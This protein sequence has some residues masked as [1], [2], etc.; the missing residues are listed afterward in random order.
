MRAL[1]IRTLLILLVLALASCASSSPDVAGDGGNDD[2]PVTQD[3]P[4][5]DA[6]PEENVPTAPTTDAARDV[7][8]TID[9]GGADSPDAGLI[10]E[11]DAGA[12][13]CG[14]TF[15]FPG[16]MFGFQP[17]PADGSFHAVVS[18]VAADHLV[19]QPDVGNS[20]TFAWRGPSLVTEFSV[21]QDVSCQQAARWSIVRSTVRTAE[22]NSTFSNTGIAQ[23]GTIPGGATYSI[24]PQCANVLF[25]PCNG[26]TT[27]TVIHTYYR[28]VVTLAGESADIPMETTVQL[29]GW[30]ITN[31]FHDQGSV[32]STTP[33]CAIDFVNLELTSALGPP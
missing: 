22:I 7:G 31:V 26:T 10:P 24:V 20:V 21:G 8:P 19:L 18:E 3:A 14:Q 5:T 28:I 6:A 33:N 15:T 30:R 16:S 12:P 32:R 29:G 13:A 23:S 4:P 27:T 1:N 11:I 9:A 2:A 17:Q 25:S